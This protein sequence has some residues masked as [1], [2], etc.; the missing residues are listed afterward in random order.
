M[1][2]FCSLLLLLL[3]LATATAEEE[4]KSR[5]A[6]S[7]KEAVQL[8]I[9][10]EGNAQIQLAGEALRQANSRSNQARAALLPNIDSSLSYRN[11]TLNLRANGLRFDIPVVQ[12]FSFAFPALVGPFNVMD[13]RIS[14]TQSIFDFSSIRRFPFSVGS[15]GL[16]S[17]IDSRPP[18][19]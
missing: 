11:Q 4:G 12:G 9:S 13:A 14:G 17:E 3:F 19:R 16:R 7:L 6:L 5:L 8:A 15:R 10:P 2:H 1:R 18:E